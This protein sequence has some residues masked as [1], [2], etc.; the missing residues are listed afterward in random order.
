MGVFLV[1]E[2]EPISGDG[3]GESTLNGVCAGKRL[4]IITASHSRLPWQSKM[5]CSRAKWSA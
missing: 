4:E 3:L 5:I 1:E 2:P